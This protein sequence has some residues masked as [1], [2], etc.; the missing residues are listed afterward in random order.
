MIG[1]LRLNFYKTLQYLKKM[2]WL[3]KMMSIYL[4]FLGWK[5]VGDFIRK[6]C[7]IWP[8]GLYKP[9]HNHFFFSW[10]TEVKLLQ[11]ILNNSPYLILFRDY[12]FT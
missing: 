10:R 2:F 4:G 6:I 12:S 8:G 9:K 7:S 3:V 11:N 5:H 1:R